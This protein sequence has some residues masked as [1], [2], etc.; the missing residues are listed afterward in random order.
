MFGGLQGD[1]NPF[2]EQDPGNGGIHGIGAPAVA[3]V[4][5]EGGNELGNAGAVDKDKGLDEAFGAVDPSQRRI[6]GER[7]PGRVRLIAAAQKMDSDHPGRFPADAVMPGDRHERCGGK[8]A[9]GSGP[10]QLGVQPGEKPWPQGGADGRVGVE[11]D[12]GWPVNRKG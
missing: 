4:N 6:S 5:G 7:T 10:G 12:R 8:V 3:H 1:V 2:M 9:G 11:N